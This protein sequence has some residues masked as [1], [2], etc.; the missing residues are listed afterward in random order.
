LT[1]WLETT[2]FDFRSACRALQH[3]RR[4]TGWVVGSLAIGMAV[5]IAALALLN[6]VMFS[7]FP[8]ITD[9]A[10]LV[11]VSVTRNCGGPDCWSR[12]SAPS[13]YDALQRGLTGLQGL[14]AYTDGQVAAALPEARSLRALVVSPNYFTL[15]GVHAAAGRL[16][17]G[18]DAEAHGA[19]AVIAYGT[20][21][22]E[23]GSDLSVVGRSIRI[24][25]D[26]VQIVGV[27]PPR[28][29]GIDRVRPED[30]DPDIWLPM[31]L[32]DRVLPFSA[33]ERRRQER[34][35]DFVGRLREGVDARQVQAQAEVLAPPLAA[36]RQPSTAA[37]SDV[38]PVSRVNPRHWKFG[39]IV[40][41]PIPILVLA[42]A[43]VNAANLM[44]A[45]GSQRQREMAVRL[46][47]GA[48][49]GRIVRQLLMESALLALIATVV[50]LGI[51][52]WGLQ[53]ATNPW[54]IQ[55]PLDPKV[56]AWT[57]LTAVVTTLAFGLAPA[58]RV[59]AL[60]PSSALGVGNA[61]VDSVPRQSRMHR[62]L[63]VAQVALSLGL[64][65]T[66]WQLVATVRGQAVSSGAP[67]NQVL[68]AR[69]NLEPLN[70]APAEAEAFF[71][72]LAVRTA[73]LPGV[74]AAGIARHTAVWTF[75][76]GATGAAIVV[77]HPNDRPDE[78]RTTIGGFAGGDLFE[79]VG[80]RVVAGRRFTEAEQRQ[81]RSQVAVVNQTFAAGMNGPAI[82]SVLRV[83][84]RDRAFASAIEVR[85]VG[86]IEPAL[87]P[88]YEEGLPAA[89]V[90]L[91]VPLEPE[92]A[93]TLYLRTHGAAAALAQPVRELVGQIAPRVPILDLGSLDEFNERSFSQQ[94]WLARGA[95]FLGVVG[96]LLATAGLY[97][98]A[99][100]VVAMRSREL[101][102]RMALGA[103][104]QAILTMILG[105][106][107]RI[108][109]VGLVAGIAA[110]AA[111][112]RIIQA[113]YYGIRGID[114]I[115]FGGAMVLF[116]AA[117]LLASTIPAVRAS[118]VHPVEN[119]KDA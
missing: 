53:L 112:S 80:L 66:A 62:L 48:R 103:R 13:D 30:R 11:R 65:A 72:E 15:L 24:A 49:R 55:V 54:D 115:A 69:F 34:L 18:S 104:P 38:R 90:Y 60:H 42:I 16:F 4:Y 84:L 36:L 114:P 1:T 113:G 37:R 99:S 76:Q 35:M 23:F 58:V 97:G 19:V 102:I 86:I 82:G 106:S 45:R 10:R 85:I 25:N 74:E 108:A 71:Q 21:T 9:Q 52:G 17:G 96:L 29:G 105:Y 110:A 33:V 31:S 28:F 40:V 81:S 100:Y 118:R 14:A 32:A 79:A 94:L 43:C 3:S 91:P 83:A 68:L 39:F 119:L 98:V 47:I 57:V 73:R 27:A 92:P 6:A 50:A 59:S 26:F 2:W 77:W 12:M 61:R 51:A 101:A 75:G 78:G 107:M 44:L 56:L 67:G 70:L 64:L 8:G 116:V 87:E 41:M 88:R 63:I 109:A 46:A 20:W 93:L 117:M 22:R 7:P 89:K 111:A 5:T 95:A